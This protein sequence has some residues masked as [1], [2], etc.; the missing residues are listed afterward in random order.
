MSSLPPAYREPQEDV[1]SYTDTSAISARWHVI[2]TPAKGLYGSR[3]I[4]LVPDSAA[5]TTPG[6]TSSINGYDLIFVDSLT[7]EVHPEAPLT[8]S[9]SSKEPWKTPAVAKVGFSPHDPSRASITFAKEEK[10]ALIV[11]SSRLRQETSNHRDVNPSGVRLVNL[12]HATG[13]V[14]PIG[15]ML[16]DNKEDIN[17]ASI[18]EKPTPETDISHSGSKDKHEGKWSWKSISKDIIPQEHKKIKFTVGDEKAQMQR[19]EL[20]SHF[21]LFDAS[22]N[23]YANFANELFK[24]PSTTAK[25]PTYEKE[26]KHH[27]SWGH[28]DIRDEQLMAIRSSHPAFEKWSV[29]DLELVVLLTL[30]IILEVNLKI[31]GGA[32][33]GSVFSQA[34]FADEHGGTGEEKTGAMASSRRAIAT[35]VSWME[36]GFGHTGTMGS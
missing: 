27:K 8:G 4:S 28:L 15:W 1:P 5:I 6:V 29:T 21:E 13:E 24:N 7:I 23:A 36:K 34:V 12:Y 18:S 20:S 22:G 33:R 3:G 30:V 10:P 35:G 32:T 2:N 17:V 16:H 11:D 19:K 9:E 25:I 26:V 14:L 31:H